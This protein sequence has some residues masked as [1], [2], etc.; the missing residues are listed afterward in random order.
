MIPLTIS[1]ETYLKLG[2]ETGSPQPE[3]WFLTVQNPD[4]QQELTFLLRAVSDI[5]LCGC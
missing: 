1:R 2:R 5:E 4:T 3:K